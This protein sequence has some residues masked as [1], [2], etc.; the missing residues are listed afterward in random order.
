MARGIILFFLH[1]GK[2]Q[3]MIKK[4]FIFNRQLR[5]DV[6]VYIYIFFLGGG[7]PKLYVGFIKNAAFRIS[8]G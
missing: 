3:P 1:I 5:K 6:S 7:D 8:E 4:L 2:K